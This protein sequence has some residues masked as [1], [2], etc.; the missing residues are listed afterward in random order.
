MSEYTPPRRI[1]P[2]TG[3]NLWT[4]TALTPA[5]WMLPLGG[6]VTAEMAGKDATE[7]AVLHARI[8]TDNVKAAS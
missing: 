6:E 1:A 8:R 2:Q 4:G 3:D 7:E 5:D